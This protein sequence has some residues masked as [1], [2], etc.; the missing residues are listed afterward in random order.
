MNLAHSAVLFPMTAAGFGLQATSTKV[1]FLGSNWI[2]EVLHLLIAPAGGH[3]HLPSLE[4]DPPP[5]E[6]EEPVNP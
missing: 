2:P 1:V 6:Q 4:A 3:G 5:L